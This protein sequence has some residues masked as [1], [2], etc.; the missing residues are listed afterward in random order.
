M[1]KWKGTK[2]LI[3]AK[4]VLQCRILKARKSIVNGSEAQCDAQEA[5]TGKAKTCYWKLLMQKTSYTKEYIWKT[6]LKFKVQNIN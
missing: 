2:S 1:C 3:S 4:T 5:R 6:D